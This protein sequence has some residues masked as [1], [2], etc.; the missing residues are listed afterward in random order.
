MWSCSAVMPR[1]RHLEIECK[2]A[3]L[4]ESRHGSH[5]WMDDTAFLRLR[6]SEVG[7]PGIAPL[8][9][10]LKQSQSHTVRRILKPAPWDDTDDGGTYVYLEYV[11]ARAEDAGLTPEYCTGLWTLDSEIV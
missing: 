11:E 7:Y 4:H 2:A 9:E 8:V 6:L 3:A 10:N 1:V 5:D